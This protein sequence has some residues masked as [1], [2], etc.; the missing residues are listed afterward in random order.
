MY[1]LTVAPGVR[2]Q[3]RTFQHRI[4]LQKY[5][6]MVSFFSRENNFFSFISLINIIKIVL[7]SLTN[8]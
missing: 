2:L 1:L 4:A 5:V 6:F 3:I 7:D 8:Q